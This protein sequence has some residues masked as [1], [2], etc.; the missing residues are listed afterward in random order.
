M[1]DS[2]ERALRATHEFFEANSGWGEPTR[3][4]LEEWLVDGVCQ[5]PDECW[6]A[7]VGVCEHGLASWLA[8]LRAMGEHA[9]LAP[10]PETSLRNAPNFRDLGGIRSSNGAT[11]ARG[12]IYRSGVFDLLDDI[13]RS[14]LRSLGI[15]TAIDLRADDERAAR[16]NQLPGG[17]DERHRPVTDVS[18]HPTTIMARIA[19]GETEGL[20][21][22]ML[23]RGNRH[24]VEAQA[25]RFGA[26]VRELLDPRNQPAV[27]HCT[28]GKDR[29]GFAIA[30]VLWTIGIGHEAVI[31]DYLRTNE[32]MRDRHE[33]TLAES[34]SR[35]ID[36]TKL[37]EML[38]VRRDYLD[39][40]Y[41]RAVELHGSVDAFIA[42]GLGFDDTERAAAAAA[43]L[44]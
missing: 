21:A 30:C 37:E 15:R 43:M 8:V 24:F 9:D 42:R 22:E 4:A 20:G 35:G 26:I 34:A 16:V 14:V 1:T 3:D 6:V 11:V 25:D 19:A 10:S 33:R 36:T 23:I 13:D 17:I 12:R 31:A 32:V 40:A 39:A 2:I 38:V 41:E 27:V 7:P 28:A 44:V 29:T 18:A 5:C